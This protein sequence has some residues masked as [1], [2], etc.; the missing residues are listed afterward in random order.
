MP[1]PPPPGE[2]TSRSAR[3]VSTQRE[4]EH[5][6]HRSNSQPVFDGAGTSAAADAITICVA[7]VAAG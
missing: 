2:A 4:G 3:S 1:P 5:I 6:V 7:A